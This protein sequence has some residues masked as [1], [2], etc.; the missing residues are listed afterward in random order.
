MLPLLKDIQQRRDF[1]L[2]ASGRGALCVGVCVC[3]GVR[4]Y[5]QPIGHRLEHGRAGESEIVQ[6]D[7]LG[8]RTSTG[9]QVIP[10]Q[11]MVLT[12]RLDDKP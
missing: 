12:F 9:E 1:A 6:G 2:G 4:S 11:W 7:A 3:A 8:T 5:W 10:L